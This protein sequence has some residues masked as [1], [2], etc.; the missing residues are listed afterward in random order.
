MFNLL[1]QEHQKEL[2]KEYARRRWVVVLTSF[3][4]LGTAALITLFPAYIISSEKEKE[5]SVDERAKAEMHKEDMT[6]L[7]QSLV[8]L[9]TNTSIIITGA[10]K[11]LAHDVFSKIIENKTS[12]ITI[13]SLVYKKTKDEPLQVAIVGIAETRDGLLSFARSLENIEIFTKVNVPVS[14]FA[15]DKNIEFSLELSEAQ[16]Q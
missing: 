14:N 9:K 4:L 8:N 2:R 3:V 1:P 5:I 16:K 12:S 10:T 6:D 7:N 15:K 13:K 11:V